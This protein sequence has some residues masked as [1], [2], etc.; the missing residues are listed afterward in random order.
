MDGT[1]ADFCTLLVTTQYSYVNAYFGDPY[2]SHVMP[3]KA[4]EKRLYQHVKTN[5][6]IN[7]NYAYDSYYIHYFI[8]KTDVITNPFAVYYMKLSD[9]ILKKVQLASG[10]INRWGARVLFAVHSGVWVGGSVGFSASPVG[11]VPLI[12]WQNNNGLD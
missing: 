11:F 6:D 5:L 10:I 2:I 7:S 4:P 12:A 9:N 3:F 8:S 1:P